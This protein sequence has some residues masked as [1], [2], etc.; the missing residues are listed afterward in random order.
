LEHI[1]RRYRRWERKPRSLKEALVGV[2]R[3]N[4]LTYEDFWALRDVTLSVARGEVVGFWGANGAG[5]TTLLKVIT[6]IVPATHGRITVRGRMAALLEL[7]TGFLPEL[8][9]RENILLNGAIMG[10]SDAEIR[11]QVDGIVDFADLGEFIDSPVRTYS[12]GMHMRLGFA[13]ASHIEADIVILDEVLAVG[14]AEFQSKCI[15]WLEA[16]KDSS[17]TVLIVS[18]SF[19]ILRAMCD[20]VVWLDRGKVVA[21]G[22]PEQVLHQYSSKPACLGTASPDVVTG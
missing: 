7:G 18:H 10:L 2:L 12:A 11:S 16:L 17:T 8:S 21:S 19:P 1:W 22:D 5:K 15:A 4:R 14:D 6:G 13:I 9:G 3:G 20:R